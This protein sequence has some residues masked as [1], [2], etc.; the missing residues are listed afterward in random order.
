MKA[1]HCSLR[2]M[3]LSK[4]AV[5]KVEDEVCLEDPLTVCVLEYAD[6]G[7]HRWIRKVITNPEQFKDELHEMFQ[8]MM[9]MGKGLQQL[10]QTTKNLI[11]QAFE[12][13]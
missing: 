12:Q 2:R 3:E 7:Q 8:H 13:G 1:F 9:L 5:V 10:P 6:P 4:V 11:Q